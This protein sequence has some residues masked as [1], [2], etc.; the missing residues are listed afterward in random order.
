MIGILIFPDFQIMNATGPAS[1]FELA[2]RLVPAAAAVQ[3]IAV[4]PGAVRS[5]SSVEVMA[6]GLR[7]DNIITTLVV[8]GGLGVEDAA[9]CEKALAFVRRL[10]QRNVRI[11]NV[12]SGAYVLAA[13]GLLNGRKAT[14]HWGRAQDFVSRYPEVRLDHERIFLRDGNIWTRR[15]SRP[16]SISL[17]QSSPRIMAKTSRKRLRASGFSHPVSPS[18]ASRR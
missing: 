10:H 14:T 17:L 11:A 9:Q 12:C 7:L 6:T 3:M 2:R 13:A 16:E 15:A 18:S 4:Q 1:V 5:S 8:A